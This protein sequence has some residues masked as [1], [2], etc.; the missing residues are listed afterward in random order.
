MIA[1]AICEIG[2]LA[3]RRIAM[4]VDPALSGLPVPHA[5]ARSTPAS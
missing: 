3:E 4:L 1:L 5:P 2:S